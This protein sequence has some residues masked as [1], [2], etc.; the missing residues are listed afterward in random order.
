LPTKLQTAQMK[1]KNQ[2]LMTK[3]AL[4]ART[5]RNMYSRGF[6]KFVRLKTIIRSQGY[7]AIG[8]LRLIKSG[9]LRGFEPLKRYRFSSHQPNLR[10]FL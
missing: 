5:V 4:P 7:F 10:F 9:S 8:K 2:Y 6:A 3:M 1:Q